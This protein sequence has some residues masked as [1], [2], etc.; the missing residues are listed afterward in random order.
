M[1]NSF[2]KTF[3]VDQS[4]RQVFETVMNVR[5][6]WQGFYEEEFTGKFGQVNDEF[7]FRAGGGMH[8]T[9]QKL[10][11]VIPDK[12]VVWLVTQSDLSFLKDTEEW[13]G[14]S[15]I[16]DI[17]KQG[18]KTELTF[19]HEGLVPEI[20]CY[21][22]CTSAW[23]MYLEEKL[24]LRI[25]S[26]SRTITVN[27]TA[28]KAF[29]SIKNFR[30]WWSEEIEGDTGELNEVF[31]YHYKDI[32]LCKIKLI[33]ATPGNKLV[34]EVVENKFNFID[35]LSEWVGTKLV[36][37]IFP[38]GKATKIIFTHEGLVP[39]YECFQVCNDA[40][41]GYIGNSLKNFIETG[42]GNPN[43]KDKEGFNAELASKWGLR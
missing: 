14:T 29:D 26:Y 2:T 7:T 36:F 15:L 5:G 17:S 24:L 25:N 6:W 27:A 1:K 37:D 33:Q 35:D 22:S 42:K 38:E 21:D 9:T 34:Y 12:K 39:D 32:H 4:P 28:S 41:N 16:F 23:S 40:W 43:P 19:T 11:E 31:F 18:D 30:G 10:I 3:L 13:K 20:E 8:N